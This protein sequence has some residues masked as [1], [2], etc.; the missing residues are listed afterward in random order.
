VNGVS[1][2]GGEVFV[3]SGS[4]S[5]FT[6]N[7]KDFSPRLGLSWQPTK[8]MVVRAG[9]GF[10]YGPSVQMVG[11]ASLD[12]DGYSSVTNWNASAWNYDPNTI[13]YDI[14]H[15]AGAASSGNSVMVNSLSNPFPGGVVQLT[16]SSQGLATSLGSTPNTMLALFAAEPGRFERA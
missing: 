4:R 3:K 6:A 11:S 15:V 7:M 10:Y 9:G 2:T 5:P 8:H 16:G 13:A 12:S 1:F 14:A